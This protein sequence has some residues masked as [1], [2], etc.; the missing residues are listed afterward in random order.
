MLFGDRILLVLV[1]FQEL[2]PSD[3]KLFSQPLSAV[4]FSLPLF[5][6]FGLILMVL[7]AVPERNAMRNAGGTIIDTAILVVLGFIAISAVERGERLVI[8]LLFTTI[9]SRL[10]DWLYTPLSYAPHAMS[11]FLALAAY[12]IWWAPPPTSTLANLRGPNLWRPKRAALIGIIIAVT[13]L[14]WSTLPI[15][16]PFE[17]L[18]AVLIVLGGYLL[19]ILVP[20]FV[21]YTVFVA[22]IFRFRAKRDAIGITA[23]VI[24]SIPFALWVLSLGLVVHA[25]STERAEVAAIPK[26]AL[27]ARFGGIVIEGDDTVLTR[28]ALEQILSAKR[29]VGDVLQHYRGSTEYYRYTLATLQSSE[30][31]NSA[32]DEHIFVRLVRRPEFL[33][34]QH[35]FADPASPPVEIYAV[36]SGGARLAAATYTAKNPPP[37]FPPLLTIG[38]WYDH[39]DVATELP[40]EH[41]KTFL[42]H[43][44]LDKLPRE[45]S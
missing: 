4:L 14:L 40:C 16:S 17:T 31:I 18:Y 5:T 39:E 19:V 30:K 9:P 7:L 27:P 25:K 45:R 44:L 12:R 42:D 22:S 13:F 34:S 15:S 11:L 3:K 32:P 1:A 6:V 21:L 26:V 38:G 36:D 29:D 20:T 8:P 33:Q 43:E 41:I 24:A 2:F 23:L 28:C 37:R 10:A 35:R